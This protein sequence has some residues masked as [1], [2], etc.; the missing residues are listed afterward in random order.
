MDFAQMSKYVNRFG[1]RLYKGK[2]SSTA[3]VEPSKAWRIP[4]TDTEIEEY[5][6]FV[7]LKIINNSNQPTIV[8][9]NG[10]IDGNDVVQAYK[11]QYP[12]PDN[13]TLFIDL[14]DNIFI[15]KD[16]LV[17]NISGGNIASDDL[18]CEFQNF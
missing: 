13:A 4:I 1:K 3:I 6:P 18:H 16:P 12:L 15:T 2:Y 14:E 11:H 7:R 10:W 17:Q 8:F 9:I 5:G